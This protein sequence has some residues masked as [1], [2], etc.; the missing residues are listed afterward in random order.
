VVCSWPSSG[1]ARHAE[2][3]GPARP[4]LMVT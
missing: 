2:H 3:G 4:D 1:R